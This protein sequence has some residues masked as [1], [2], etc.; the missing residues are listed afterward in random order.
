MKNCF[1]AVIFFLLCT[2]SAFGSSTDGNEV[3]RKCQ[4][5]IRVVD[6]GRLSA[7]D[8]SDASWCMGWIEGVLDMNNLTG[9]IADVTDSKKSALYFCASD[10]IKVGQAVRVVVKYLQDHPQQLDLPG[11][12]LAVMA[13]KI[14][15][16]CK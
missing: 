10:G 4:T 6:E 1:V 15:F 2:S 12:S 8:S 3:L 9:T 14:A 7:G 13:L 5:A 16:P 11:T